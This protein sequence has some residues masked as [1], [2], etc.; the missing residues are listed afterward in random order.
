MKHGAVYSHE[1]KLY[2]AASRRVKH[3]K[4]GRLQRGVGF[5]NNPAVFRKSCT[6]TPNKTR[7]ACRN[8][9]WGA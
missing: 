3:I 4:I 7:R 2:L 1:R 9:K 6:T 5:W 8:I